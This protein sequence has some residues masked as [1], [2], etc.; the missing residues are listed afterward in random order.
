VRVVVEVA[1]F[2]IYI[3]FDRVIAS[4]SNLKIFTALKGSK[5]GS[6]ISAFCKKVDLSLDLSKMD[7]LSESGGEGLLKVSKKLSIIRT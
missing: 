2:N 5:T 7:K 4:F 6:L 3:C 1:D